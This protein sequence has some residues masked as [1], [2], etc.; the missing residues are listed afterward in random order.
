MLINDAIDLFFQYLIVEKG[1]SKETINAY[2]QDFKQF[3]KVFNDRKTTKDL[4]ISDL[5]DFIKIQSKNK[6][7][8]IALSVDKI[9]IKLLIKTRFC[10][11]LI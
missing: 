5:T 1:V 9:K 7:P 3:F 8:T 10:F 4:F 6:M 11:G 2:Q